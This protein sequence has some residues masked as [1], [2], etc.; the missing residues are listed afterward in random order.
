MR[1][2]IQYGL[3]AVC[4]LFGLLV[5]PF[6]AL[7]APSGRLDG[8]VTGTPGGATDGR[9]VL[10]VAAP[11][12]D[13]DRLI[14]RSGGQVVGARRAALGQL[15]ASPDPGFVQR[16]KSNGAWVVLDGATTSLFCGG[17]L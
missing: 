4:L 2:Y 8:G 15:G 13:L 10:V 11:W 17:D 3:L 16:L 9:P 7:A 14:T 6:L 5:V 12:A 1:V